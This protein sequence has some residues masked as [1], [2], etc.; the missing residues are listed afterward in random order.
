V[1]ETNIKERIIRVK[2]AEDDLKL[3]Q[4]KIMDGK[5]KSKEDRDQEI[6][7]ILL[8]KKVKRFFKVERDV[9]GLGFSFSIND[10]LEATNKNEGYQI[11][12]T[13]EKELTEKDVIMSYRA[14][15]EIEKAIESLKND[16]GLRP[17]YVWNTEH[18]IGQIFVCA[19]AYQLRSIMARELR[20]YDIKLKFDDAIWKLDRLK[21]VD[22]IAT[23]DEIQTIRKI[24]TMDKDQLLLVNIFKLGEIEKGLLDTDGNI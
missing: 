5:I 7:H 22:I 3:L 16:L 23:G 4:K 11:F 15:D 13:T 19:M 12:V 2:N 9:Q 24:T 1:A 21:V 18:V 17:M 6:G 20:K 14:R 10:K 8:A